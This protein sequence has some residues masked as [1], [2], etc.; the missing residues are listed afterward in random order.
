MQIIHIITTD[1][2]YGTVNDIVSYPVFEEQLEDEVAERVEKDF[3]TLIKKL[4]PNHVDD[5][6]SIIEDGYYQY[7]DVNIEIVWGYTA[8]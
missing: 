6:E 2:N 3:A 7:N 8:D 5:I 4:D 1:T